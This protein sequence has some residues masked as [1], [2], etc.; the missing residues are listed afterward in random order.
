MPIF[1][2]QVSDGNA[3]GL[4]V[5]DSPGH[6]A[7]AGY[8]E[9]ERGVGSVLCVG[10]SARTGDPS[11]NDARVNAG[12]ERSIELLGQSADNQRF[13]L[14]AKLGGSYWASLISG[15]LAV[16]DGALT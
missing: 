16:F 1:L 5:W 9:I 12:G 10:H 14:T 6:V 4:H 8:N 3:F 7:G 15:E 2:C 11:G 13:C